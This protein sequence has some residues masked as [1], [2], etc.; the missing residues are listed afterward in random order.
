MT[1]RRAGSDDLVSAVAHSMPALRRDLEDL[2]RIPSVSVPG[3]LDPP[4]LEAFEATTPPLRR[5]RRRRR[6]P[7]PARHGAGRRR[8]DPSATGRADGPALQPLRRRACRRRG[9]LELPTVRADR[10]RRRDLRARSGGHQVQHHDARRGAARLGRPAAG[11]RPALH[12]GLRGDRQRRAAELPRL[13]P[14]AVSRRRADHRRH[15]QHRARHADADDRP[16]RDGQRDARGP[17]AASPASTA[18]STA[19]RR[20]TR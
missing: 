16:A 3:Q 14:R 5:R 7:R 15:G 1:G 6:P 13:R 4:L 2:V 8:R 19:A 17:H 9:A 10:A 20:P 18:G 12:R 11:R